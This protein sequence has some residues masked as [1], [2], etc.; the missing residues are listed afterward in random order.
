M[1]QTVYTN[2]WQNRLTGVKKEHGSYKSEEEAVNGIKAWWELHKEDYPDA[3]YNRTNTGALEI[4][5]NDDHYFYRVEKRKTDKPLPKSN[6]KLRNKNE[7]RSIREKYDLHEEAY[8]YEELAEPYRDRL[9]LA[10]NDGQKLLQ[11]T[12]DSEG[13]PIRKLTDK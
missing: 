13:R 5:Y 2:Y 4:I 12:F 11:Y 6:V 3:E 8:L 7:V 10:M 9:M 1:E